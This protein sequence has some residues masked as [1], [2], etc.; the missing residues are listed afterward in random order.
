MSDL[1]KALAAWRVEG[2][3]AGFADRVLAPR[4]ERSA[5]RRSSWWMVAG[6]A[7]A[8]AVILVVARFSGGPAS[9]GAIT[10]DERTTLELP[11]AVA[12]AE[13]GAS[14][15]W[16]TRDAAVEVEQTHGT[17]FYRV[18]RGSEFSVATPL[19]RVDVEGTSFEVEIEMRKSTH[20][21]SAAAGVALAAAVTVTL[22]EG[23][24]LVANAEGKTALAPGEEAELRP[25]RAPT[26][27]ARSDTAALE[28]EV[29]QLREQ[30]HAE[31][32]RQALSGATPASSPALALDDEDAP[33]T[34]AEVIHRC[35]MTINGGP[36]CP[37]LH[38]SQDVLEH[39]ADCGVVVYD[40]PQALESGNVDVSELAELAGLDV[41]ERDRL[42]EANR[43]FHEHMRA[44]F[45]RIHAELGGDAELGAKLST[46]ALSSEIDRLTES[47]GAPVDH[48]Q[49]A[50]E[51]YAN[52]LAGRQPA[53]GLSE[54]SPGVR[55][56]YVWT[57]AGD[58]YEEW[59]AGRIGEARARELREVHDGW[60]GNHGMQGVPHCPDP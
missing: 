6:L 26:K 16:S 47:D 24:V 19:G 32:R 51:L 43:S 55:H 23:H 30:L 11:R 58:L 7:L 36:S 34:P 9:W 53:P 28:A 48:Y 17:V 44:E 31:R 21:A 3:P 20:I 12:V 1:E 10:V 22:Y 5:P 41:R 13:P 8:A 52:V 56:A 42:V 18:D 25:G 57:A 39:R 15:Q 45:E 49:S 2:A 14:L 35:A 33:R 38:P 46:A 40:R 50:A 37:M 60:T 59:L 27:A 4:R 54:L 29:A